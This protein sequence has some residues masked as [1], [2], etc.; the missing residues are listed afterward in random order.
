MRTILGMTLFALVIGYYIRQARETQ[1][2]NAKLKRAQSP[3]DAKER[4]RIEN[5]FIRCCVCIF[6][7]GQ[8]NIFLLAQLSA[9]REV[10]PSILAQDSANHDLLLAQVC[11]DLGFSNLLLVALLQT[12][13]LSS[14]VVT[15]AVKAR[16]SIL[17][18][19]RMCYVGF[20]YSALG[21][22]IL[23][24]EYIEIRLIWSAY[25]ILGAVTG[26][27]YGKTLVSLSASVKT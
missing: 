1:L 21:L 25:V 23:R 6:V 22:L 12:L 18:V 8:L 26:I 13:V 9:M 24:L 11:Y 7:T 16:I 5:I 17:P 14:N 15:L 19:L 3:R 27:L 20:L 2:G 10:L 4:T